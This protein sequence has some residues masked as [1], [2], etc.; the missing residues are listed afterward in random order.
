MNKRQ[1]RA[2]LSCQRQINKAIDSCL[3]KLSSDDRMYAEAY[4]AAHIRSAINGSSYGSAPIKKAE[5]ALEEK[6]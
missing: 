2:M 4:W 3:E 5:S 1:A 6:V